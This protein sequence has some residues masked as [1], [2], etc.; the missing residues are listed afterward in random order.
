MEILASADFSYRAGLKAPILVFERCSFDP[1][2]TETRQK[3]QNDPV[4]LGISHHS[5]P[6]NLET[7]LDTL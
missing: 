3:R 7:Q 1:S 6:K 5:L 2:F 4:E